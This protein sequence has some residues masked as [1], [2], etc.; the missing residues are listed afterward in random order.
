MA[1]ILELKTISSSYLK[2]IRTH[3]YIAYV[4]ANDTL[5]SIFYSLTYIGPVLCFFKFAIEDAQVCNSIGTLFFPSALQKLPQTQ[6]CP[7]AGCSWETGIQPYL[8]LQQVLRT[9]FGLF[10][11]KYFYLVGRQ[12]RYTEIKPSLLAG[13][14]LAVLQGHRP[15]LNCLWETGVFGRCRS[16]WRDAVLFL[17][18]FLN[19][20]LLKKRFILHMCPFYLSTVHATIPL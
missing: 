15:Q 17:T 1:L 5:N 2:I 18:F 3:T 11:T 7:A 6:V 9:V 14:I 16:I 12:A 4:H 10:S 19:P 8:I 20:F 13:E